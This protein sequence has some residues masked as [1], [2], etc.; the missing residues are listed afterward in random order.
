MTPRPAVWL[1]A[2]VI[3]VADQASKVWALH[4]LEDGRRIDIIGDTLGLELV[5]NPGAALSLLDGATWVVTLIMLAVTVG[6]LWF[7]GRAQGFL[8]VLVFG[9]ALGGAIG[10]LGDR[11][12][13]APSFGQGHVIDMI[14]YNDYFTGNVADI[15]IV[16]AATVAVLSSWFGVHLL[17]SKAAVGEPVALESKAAPSP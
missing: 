15:A 6:L 2:L 10:N 11:L 4:A 12:F 9:A 1:V 17:R 14:N 8:G 7:H 13:R 16:G 3:A 5:R